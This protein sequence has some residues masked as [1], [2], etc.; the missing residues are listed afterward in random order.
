MSRTEL[1]IGIVD[2]VC[3]Q[4]IQLL[5]LEQ[6]PGQILVRMTFAVGIGVEPHQH[7][8]VFHGTCPFLISS[9]L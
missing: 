7:R 5:T 6:F 8:R 3:R 2:V 9:I 1:C 4:V